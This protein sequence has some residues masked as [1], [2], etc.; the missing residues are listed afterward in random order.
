MALHFL[1]FCS[2]NATPFGSLCLWL[3]VL[4]DAGDSYDKHGNKDFCASGAINNFTSQLT[5]FH[6]QQQS[7]PL[8]T[9]A[10][11]TKC[12]CQSFL[13]S[14]LD[15]FTADRDDQQKQ[16]PDAVSGFMSKLCRH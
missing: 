16:L 6:L 9:K 14:T 12:E 5:E 11:G 3:V 2:E 15:L 13:T 8:L 10:R 4:N 1:I 7:G